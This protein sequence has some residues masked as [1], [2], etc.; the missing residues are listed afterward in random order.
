MA[1][2]VLPVCQLTAKA[3]LDALLAGAVPWLVA[4][5]LAEL[6]TM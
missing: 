6:M 2:L 5:L 3:L 1:W 4:W